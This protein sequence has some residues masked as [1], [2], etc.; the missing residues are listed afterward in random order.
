MMHTMNPY[1][2]YEVLFDTTN[3]KFGSIPAKELL[4]VLSSGRQ[5]GVLLE[6]EVAARFSNLTKDNCGQGDGPDLIMKTEN[7]NY[8][9]QCKTVRTLTDKGNPKGLGTDIGHI[10]K[11]CLFDQTRGF[12]EKTKKGLEESTWDNTHNSYFG[13]YDYFMFIDIS[14]FKQGFFKVL[15]VPTEDLKNH[16][17]IESQQKNYHFGKNGKK[18]I[19]ASYPPTDWNYPNKMTRSMWLEWNKKQEKVC[20]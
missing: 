20:E 18:K 8:K 16:P 6:Y 14:C 2:E 5:C 11:S 4:A 1:T 15:L 3:I 17:I 12:N 9:V 19:V 13:E 10:T 7:G